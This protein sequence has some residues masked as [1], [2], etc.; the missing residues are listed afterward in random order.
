MPDAGHCRGDYLDVMKLRDGRQVWTALMATA[1]AGLFV[2]CASIGPAAAQINPPVPPI[3][4]LPPLLPPPPP[5]PAMILGPL[6]QSPPAGAPV[7]PRRLDT[8]SDRTTRCLHYGGTQGLRGEKLDT[9][10]R[11]CVND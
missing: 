7:Q 2:G 3:N 6:P 9:F 1:M 10:T 8:H 5:P 4:S 11:E